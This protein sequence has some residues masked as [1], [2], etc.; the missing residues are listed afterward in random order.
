MSGSGRRFAAR[1]FG[2]GLAAACLG[3]VA[4][5][6]VGAWGSAGLMAGGAVVA[7]GCVWLRLRPARGSNAVI[8]RWN[9]RTRRH[10]GTASRWDL[11][12]TSSSW[13]MRR[14]AHVLRPSLAGLS[15]MQRWRS[16]VISYAV[17]LCK[18]GR[19]TVW[20]S[21]QESTLR[22]GIPGTGKTAEL[23][24]RVLDAPGGVV[25]TSTAA[26]LYELTAP[27]RRNAGPVEV[28][29]PGGLGGIDSTLRWSPLAGCTDPVV[30]ARRAND[31]MGPPSESAEGERWAVQ[32]RRVLAVL[33]HAAALG[34]HRLADV[35]AW[36]SNPDAARA[37]ILQALTGSPQAAEM[38]QAAQ[39][40]IGM[41][42]RTRD[43]VLLTI[44]PA[45]AWV[46]QPAAAACGD[47]VVGVP[48]FAV[49]RLVDERGSLFLLG[50]DDGTVA[51]LVGALTAEIAWQARAL[52]ATRPG[53]RLDPGLTLALD[54]IALVC[55]TP[56]DRWM[57]ELRK[58]NVVI[59]AA[60]QGI[61]QLR[62]RWGTD[63]ASMII[64]SAA[65]V[66]LF[67]G[68]K[69][70][71]DLA[72]FA[73]LIGERDEVVVTR[74]SSGAVTS[75]STRRV[76]VISPAMLAALPNHQVLLVRRGMPVAVARTPIAWR[77]KDVRR[78][79][80]KPITPKESPCST[81]P[82][83]QTATPKA[84]ATARPHTAARS[85]PTTTACSATATTAAGSR[86]AA[87]QRL[88]KS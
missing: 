57:S 88:T 32:G 18:V 47:P 24:C 74:D 12:R 11:L 75:T 7:A 54:E 46:T 16:P 60:C 85:T 21:G 81:T 10:Q 37:E 38:V 36:V 63:G 25:V 2:A 40:A 56:L 65:A 86:T 84:S 72:L 19:A 44:V 51:P 59:H 64:N 82:P 23:A 79:N 14:Q 49:A 5:D 33:L 58:R 53:G 80:R 67:G 17:P 35:H 77:R 29:N 31:L 61:G 41:T 68:C 78:A 83:P 15:R 43:G 26:D 6:V 71:R 3:W 22:I 70:D 27:V 42:P 73:N 8:G 13:A 66:M 76:P 30:A 1:T 45:L 28:F 39:Q 50:D 69:D 9:R 52:A 48:Q 55:P 4:S 87:P 62:Q 20:T 34:G